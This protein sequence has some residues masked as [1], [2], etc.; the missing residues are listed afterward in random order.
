MTLNVRFFVMPLVTLI[1]SSIVFF[2]YDPNSSHLISEDHLPHVQTLI[3]IIGGLFLIQGFTKIAPLAPP[4]IIES[5]KVE[6]HVEKK[7]VEE[8]KP[9]KK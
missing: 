1:L 2:Y 5:K 7:V 6:N 3:T 4:V 9:E 8:K